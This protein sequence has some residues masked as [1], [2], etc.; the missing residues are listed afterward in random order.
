[1]KIA[2]TQAQKAF[3]MGEV[4]VGAVLCDADGNIL[5]QTHNLCETQSDIT[6]HAEI[7]AIRQASKFLNNSRLTGCSLWV[8]LE[9]C[10]MCMAAIA[11][12]RIK[13]VYFAAYD[14]K[15]GGSFLHAHKN[16]HHNV[17]IYGGIMEQEASQLMRQFFALRR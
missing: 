2:L 11:L 4:P 16:L 10:P 9:P 12:A 6:Q 8:T 7:L 14:H 5:T 15:S 1:M 17:E 13:Y 3:D